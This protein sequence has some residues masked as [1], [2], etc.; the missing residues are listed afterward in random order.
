M[1]KIQA[2]RA[3]FQLRRKVVNSAPKVSPVNRGLTASRA[4][5]S[6]AA[7]EDVADSNDPRLLVKVAHQHWWGRR[8]IQPAGSRGIPTRLPPMGG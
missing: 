5:M 7:C 6:D 8:D 2:Q 3:V 4:R 1:D